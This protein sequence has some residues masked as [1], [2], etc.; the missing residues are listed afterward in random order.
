[1][2]LF[3]FKNKILLFTYLILTFTASSYAENNEIKDYLS[4]IANDIYQDGV[5][6]V[7]NM[8]GIYYRT[9]KVPFESKNLPVTM[10][11][12]G[13]LG[14]SLG[15]D[16][17]FRQWKDET[18]LPQWEKTRPNIDPPWFPTIS[19]V[20]PV[21]P[22]ETWCLGFAELGYATS[23]FLRQERARILCLNLIQ[24]TSH[25]FI[26]SRAIKA[27]AGRARPYGPH[28]R[29]HTPWEWGQFNGHF[30]DGGEFSSFP[31]F[32]A[33]YYTCYSTILMDFIGSRWIGSVIVSSVMIAGT[34]EEITSHWLSDIFAGQLIGYSLAIS[35]IHRS[36][37]QAATSTEKPRLSAAPLQDGFYIQYTLPF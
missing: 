20:E 18:W 27:I 11:S 31:A 15:Y 32:H 34:R 30:G 9:F 22:L 29:Q 5:Q 23:L 36:Q 21:E 24:A 25:S 17:E 26:M 3:K 35:I 19:P 10:T 6:S 14:L 12:L 1:M 33:I 2:F 7:L 4:A 8:P 28:G 16:S 13:I 37:S